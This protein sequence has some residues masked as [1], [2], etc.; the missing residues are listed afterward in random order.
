MR[1]CRKGEMYRDGAFATGV[2]AVPLDRGS[3]DLL[4]RTSPGFDG[5]TLEVVERSA[6]EILQNILRV[7]CSDGNDIRQSQSSTRPVVTCSRARPLF[8]SA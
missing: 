4:T 3:A 2:L 8:R 7:E 5:S 1:F 6:I